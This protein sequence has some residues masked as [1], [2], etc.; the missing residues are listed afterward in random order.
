MQPAVGCLTGLRVLD[1]YLTTM[2]DIKRRFSFHVHPWFE[3]F[4]AL[5]ALT[6]TGSRIHE[7]WKRR[8]IA[9]LPRTFHRKFTVLGNSPFLWPVIADAT[10]QEPLSKTFEERFVQL[11]RLPEEEFQRTVLFGIFHDSVAV[12]RL[13]SDRTELFHTITRISRLKKEWLSFLGLYPPKKG[14]PLFSA[15]ELLLR[16]PKQ[17]HRTLMD[18]IEIFWEKEFQQTWQSL[19][20]KLESSREEKERLFH[21]CSLEEFARL[22][23]LRIEIDSRK[24][25]IKAVRGGYSLPFNRIREAFVLPSAFND[26][27]HWTTYEQ[28]EGALAYFPYFDPGIS[29]LPYRA[30]EA[31]AQAETQTDPAL[32]LK[33]LGDTTRY[34]MASLLGKKPSSS[35]EL[36]KTLDVSA[37]TISHH[38]HILREAG[39]LRERVQG[40]AVAIS[41]NR[42][43]LESLSGLL[44]QELF[45]S[46]E[47]NLRKSRNK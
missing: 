20:Y 46:T 33:A 7:A 42:E 22:A 41:L 32:I 35:A 45:D 16:L 30:G 13:L 27:R 8:A 21:S 4:F 24:Q 10:L 26:K 9:K 43:T 25:S 40:N 47:I 1:Y 37:A 3:V 14:T 5:Q 36:A 31:P 17:F 29:L 12:E 34:A 23:L 6:D 19:R 11:S 38:I 2:I 28:G 15:L 39:L 18:V 44:I